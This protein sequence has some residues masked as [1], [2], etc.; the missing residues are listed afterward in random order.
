MADTKEEIPYG[1]EKFEEK[2]DAG[3]LEG[4]VELNEEDD[5]P[6]EEVRVTVPSKYFHSITVG[7]THFLLP[8]SPSQH[9]QASITN[10]SHL[11]TL[12]PS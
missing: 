10:G 4:Q 5:S 9:S 8:M 1:D 12:F 2:L 6:I 7:C 11:P 3:A